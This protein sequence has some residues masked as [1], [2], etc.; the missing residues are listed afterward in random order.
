LHVGYKIA[1]EMGNKYLKA[2]EKH[3]NI[4]AKCV[5]E[6]IYQRHI[7]PLFLE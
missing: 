4:I 6:N 2:L 3:K 1:A 7:K 5:T